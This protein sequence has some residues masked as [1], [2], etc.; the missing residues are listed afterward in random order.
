MSIDYKFELK[1]L[2]Q[3]DLTHVKIVPH[4]KRFTLVSKGDETKPHDFFEIYK[5][6]KALSKEQNNT[7]ASLLKLK[8]FVK[9]L[10]TVKVHATFMS[11]FEL[12]TP[13]EK[14]VNLQRSIRDKISE[15]RQDLKDLLDAVNTGNAKVIRQLASNRVNFNED[16]DGAIPLILAVQNGHIEVVKALLEGGANV[17]M[18]DKFGQSPIFFAESVEVMKLLKEK[19]ADL[20]MQDNG[21]KTVIVRAANARRKD[22]VDILSEDKTAPVLIDAMI[23]QDGLFGAVKSGDVE[24]INRL[25]LQGVNFNVQEKGISLLAWG[26]L[27]GRVEMVKA[28]LAGGADV[29]W[30]GDAGKP[31]LFYVMKGGE[32]AILDLLIENKV[33][34]DFQDIRGRTF[35]SYASSSGNISV[36][37]TLLNHHVEVN[38]CDESNKSPLEYALAKGHNEIA[39][40]LFPF[41]QDNE[42]GLIFPDKPKEKGTNYENWI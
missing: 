28:L 23:D 27:K 24:V 14:A 35:L 40:M 9:Q 33:N 1:N 12:E 3:F 42:K 5:K 20:H 17:N 11:C 36:V 8:R 26:V 32:L 16:C 41:A 38:L 34:L 21:G 15:R 19:N 4:N 18:K 13:K 29:N 30:M 31:P 39:E 7:I 10:K 25:T 2:G 22:L 37:K 6:V